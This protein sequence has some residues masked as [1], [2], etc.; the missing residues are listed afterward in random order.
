MHDGLDVGDKFAGASLD[1]LVVYS[2]TWEGWSQLRAAGLMLKCQ[3]GMAECIYILYDWR[4]KGQ[5]GGRQA[6]GYQAALDSKNKERILGISAI[7][8]NLFPA[9]LTF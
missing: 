6:G 2:T 3:F 8:K 1:D 5:D 7:I 4:R 9:S